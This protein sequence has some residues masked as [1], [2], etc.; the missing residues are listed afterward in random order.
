MLRIASITA[1]SLCLALPALG[2]GK[3]EVFGRIASFECGDNCYLTIT[4]DTGRKMTGLCS[5]PMCRPWNDKAEMPGRLVGSR[6]AATVGVGRQFD[7]AG[8]VMG[9]TTAFTKLRTVR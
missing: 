2:Q 9:R 1:L 4:T 6:V 8:N 5:A 7:G 3:R